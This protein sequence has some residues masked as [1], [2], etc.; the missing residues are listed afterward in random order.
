MSEDAIVFILVIKCITVWLVAGYLC[1]TVEAISNAW[2]NH[3]QQCDVES[4]EEQ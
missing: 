3:L 4:E 2:I 1:R